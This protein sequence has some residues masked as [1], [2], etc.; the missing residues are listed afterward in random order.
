MLESI[1]SR[2]DFPILLKALDKKMIGFKILSKK[3]KLYS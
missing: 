3:P 1:F 2:G